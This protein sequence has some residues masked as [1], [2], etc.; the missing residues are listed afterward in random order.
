MV[1]KVTILEVKISNND[2]NSP[3]IDQ[4]EGTRKTRGLGKKTIKKQVTI[5]SDPSLS[6][7]KEKTE[8]VKSL[9]CKCAK[10]KCLKMYCEC[11]T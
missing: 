2:E 6:L 7:L 5:N 8:T 11:F 9:A 1:K 4:S 10:S 3:D